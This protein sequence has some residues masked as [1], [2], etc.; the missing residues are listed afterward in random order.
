MSY[1]NENRH[2]CHILLLLCSQVLQT[3]PPFACGEEEEKKARQHSVALLQINKP[4]LIETSRNA[5]G[6][7]YSRDEHRRRIW[8]CLLKWETWNSILPWNSRKGC[9]C[10]LTDEEMLRRKCKMMLDGPAAVS[11][12]NVAPCRYCTCLPWICVRFAGTRTAKGI[13]LED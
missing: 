9:L 11:A 3:S 2:N 4:Q 1:A 12:D 7:R 10:R 13:E 8:A 5:A 6:M